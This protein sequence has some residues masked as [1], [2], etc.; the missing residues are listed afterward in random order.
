MRLPA[1]ARWPIVLVLVLSGVLAAGDASAASNQHQGTPR[2][3]YVGTGFDR[4]VQS[5]TWFTLDD[6]EI[7][8]QWS[9]GDL[10]VA[11]F[12]AESLC[13]AKVAGAYG[14]CSVRIVLTGLDAG[15]GLFPFTPDTGQYFAFDTADSTTY[16]YRSL[17]MT[18]YLQVPSDP[19]DRSVVW[20]Q[21]AV[22]NP[23]IEFR[24]DD[25]VLTVQHAT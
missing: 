23:N 11:T 14:W 20:V 7:L 4:W 13:H 25:A 17:S 22:N 21:A 5:T 12:S 18:R 15:S 6:P 19:H 1:G 9:T 8:G 10:L 16:L 2:R 3:I 24:L